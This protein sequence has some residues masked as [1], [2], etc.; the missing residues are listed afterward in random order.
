MSTAAACLCLMHWCGGVEGCRPP[1][2]LL[3]L[4]VLVAALGD[5][6][7]SELHNCALQVPYL[8]VRSITCV[9]RISD[10]A[11]DTG[12]RHASRCTLRSLA[13]VH[14]TPGLQPWN[15]H[16]PRFACSA[17]WARCTDRVESRLVYWQPRWIVLCGPVSPC[18]LSLR[19]WRIG[20]GVGNVCPLRSTW[21]SPLSPVT[22]LPK[23]VYAGTATT[24]VGRISVSSG[25]VPRRIGR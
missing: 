14:G 21:A 4:A 23:A 9:V 3:G 17:A 12:V 18:G 2:I 8:F 25:L 1:G 11:R 24:R 13:V 7:I 16:S 19:G 10:R 5:L 15:W 6:A 20:K 22:G